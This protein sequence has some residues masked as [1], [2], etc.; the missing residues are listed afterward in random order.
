MK[1]LTLIALISIFAMSLS[2]PAFSKQVIIECKQGNNFLYIWNDKTGW[3]AGE[4]F[5][6][7]EIELTGKRYIV[8][9]SATF[10]NGSPDSKA[11]FKYGLVDENNGVLKFKK[12]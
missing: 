11:E 12:Y 8:A 9:I 1:K 3:I 7:R 2:I 5:P 4:A 10:N 6:G